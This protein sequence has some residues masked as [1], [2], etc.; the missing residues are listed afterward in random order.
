MEPRGPVTIKGKGTMWTYWLAPAVAAAD[1]R[2]TEMGAA[3]AGSAVADGSSSQGRQQLQAAEGEAGGRGGA[4]GVYGSGEG[5]RLT[6]GEVS[7]PPSLMAAGGAGGAGMRPGMGA[8]VAAPV[9]AMPSVPM[10]HVSAT[11]SGVPHQAAAS[12][13]GTAAASDA[14]PMAAGGGGGSGG[15]GLNHGTAFNTAGGA[16]PVVSGGAAGGMVAVGSGVM[17]P[18]ASSNNTTESHGLASGG[19]SRSEGPASVDA[20]VNRRCGVGYSSSTKSGRVLMSLAVAGGS[21]GSGVDASVAA[22]GGMGAGPMTTLSRNGGG[23]RGRVSDRLTP[24]GIGAAGSSSGIVVSGCGAGAN[25]GVFYMPSHAAAFRVDSDD[26]PI[27]TESAAAAAAASATGAAAAAAFGGSSAYGIGAA[28]AVASPPTGVMLRLSMPSPAGSSPLVGSHAAPPSTG[29]PSGG[30]PSY[31]SRPHS[32][33]VITETSQVYG[34]PSGAYS[35][36]GTTGH[37]LHIPAAALEG[38]AAAAAG[39]AAGV[40]PVGSPQVFQSGMAFAGA[41][42]AGH[43]YGYGHGY[44]GGY[45]GTGAVSA[46]QHG[47]VSMGSLDVAASNHMV[48]SPMLGT[49]MTGA[50]GGAVSGSGLISSGRRAQ[51][52][53]SHMVSSDV[54]NSMLAAAPS[55]RE[56]EREKPIGSNLIAAMLGSGIGDRKAKRGSVDLRLFQ[57]SPRNRDRGT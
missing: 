51:R 5:D 46:G 33:L 55:E 10:E 17:L 14:T 22:A 26:P 49:T 21:N 56:R 53:M 48:G 39:A 24:V 42:A 54:V 25:G 36:A 38:A 28:G 1:L 37:G 34:A 30:R 27:G 50:S 40:L 23:G 29:L 9:Y 32:R 43:G 13:D 35:S 57:Q 16:G 41:A 3:V 4:A 45:G 20:A 12:L 19:G 47:L 11:N 18:L 2:T 8:A 44:G 6:F 7:L 15:R 31:S 52:T